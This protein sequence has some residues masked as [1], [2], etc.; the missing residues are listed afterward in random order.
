[1]KDLTQGNEG[2]VMLQF[3]F[4]L[5][6]GNIFQQL[7][8]IADTIIVG[9][10]IGTDALAAVGSSFSIVVFLTSI[11]IGL[12]MGSSTLFAHF[13][14][15][16][17]DLLLKKSIFNGFVFVGSIALLL[18]IIVLVFIDSILKLVHTPSII[19]APTKAYLVVIFWGLGFTFLY[20][21]FASLL[22]ALGNSLTPLIFLIISALIN[23]VLDLVFIIVFKW[24]ISGAALATIIAQ[25]ISAVFCVIYCFIKV[26][27]LRFQLDDLKLDFSLL[28]EIINYS[29]LTSIQQSIMNFGILM[30]QGLVNTFGV[31]VMAAFAAAV[32][33]DAFAYM[34]AQDF[35]NAFSIYMAQNKGAN[36]P[37]RMKRGIKVACSI[38][39][40][41]CILASACVLIFSTNLLTLFIPKN[42]L[43]IIQYGKEYLWIVGSFYILIG[44][45][46]LFYGYYRGVGHTNISVVLTV[47]SLGLRVAL[48]YI[49]APL[50]G[51]T[52]IWWAIPIG[53]LI[54]D[55]VGLYLYFR[56][57]KNTN[58]NSSQL[59]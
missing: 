59:L 54:A 24:G 18:N 28:K 20:N 26:P 34:P 48:A 12:C 41:F 32:K 7:Y 36:K 11:I 44:Y 42:Q 27:L 6:I 2:R 56:F 8:N 9:K 43:E 1:M 45:L 35:G 21:Y 57:N 25:G 40:I 53:W 5:I 19:F 23:I 29:V 4:P 14:G 50:F 16:K 30:I 51:V 46:F 38:S 15:A 10:Y 49:C 55:G 31:A 58:S 22:R 47:I 33:I 39:T 37:L 17:K 13:F 52:A 3:A